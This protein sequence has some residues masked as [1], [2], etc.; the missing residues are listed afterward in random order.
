MKTSTKAVLLSALVLPGAGHLYLKQ[1]VTG[2]ALACISI[3]GVYYLLARATEQAMQ[4]AA[5][6]QNGNVP[7]DAAAITELAAAQP[8]GTDATLQSIATAAIMICWVIGMVD[9]YR[10]GAARDNAN[11]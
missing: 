4:I 1:Y 9:S 10:I 5:Q 3:T 7:L 8:A 2:F 6:I 11:K